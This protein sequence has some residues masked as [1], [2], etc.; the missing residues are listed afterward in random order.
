MRDEL[1][2]R[3]RE[4]GLPKKGLALLLG[5]AATQVSQMGRTA[6]VPAYVETIVEAWGL[7]SNPKRKELLALVSKD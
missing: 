3:L 6:P 5:K 7:L 4:V 2:V 1:N